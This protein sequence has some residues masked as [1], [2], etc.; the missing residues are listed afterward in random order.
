MT[1]IEL[2]NHQVW[3]DFTD[4]LD[5]LDVNILVKKHLEL[6]NYQ[7]CGYWD[8]QDN[9][10]ETIILPHTIEAELIS[11]SIG[12][13]HKKRFIQLKFV[14]QSADNTTSQSS[15]HTQKI[16]ELLLIYDENLEFVDEN[17]LLDIASPLLEINMLT[18]E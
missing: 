9:Y 14:L 4:I 8:E 11:S 10:Y 15:N 7:V 6:S 3:R 5:N 16:G 13:T 1:G 18:P 2:K 17:W 12:I